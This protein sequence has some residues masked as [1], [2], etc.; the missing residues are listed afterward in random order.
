LE[1][2]FTFTL[3]CRGTVPWR[4]SVEGGAGTALNTWLNNS[5]NILTLK[6]K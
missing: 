2:M 6:A 1:I 3:P 4:H 5:I